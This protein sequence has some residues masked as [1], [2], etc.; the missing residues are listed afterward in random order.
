MKATSIYFTNV[1]IKSFP[2]LLLTLVLLSDIKRIVETGWKHY[3]KF[4]PQLTLVEPD[5]ENS[6]CLR[7][8]AFIKYLNCIYFGF[9]HFNLNLVFHTTI[10]FENLWISLWDL[11]SVKTFRGSFNFNL[12]QL[13]HCINYWLWI[14]LTELFFSTDCLL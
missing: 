6:V 1:S 11:K 9:I 7:N 3:T 12:Y 13:R 10:S 8:F 14:T 4:A 5:L 2:A